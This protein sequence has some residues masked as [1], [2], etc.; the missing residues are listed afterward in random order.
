VRAG[1]Q[2]E[3][4][5]QR[6]RRL[7]GS[8]DPVNRQAVVVERTI[9]TPGRVLDGA[10]HQPCTGRQPDRLRDNARRVAKPPLEIR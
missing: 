1:G 8:S 3:W 7:G 10:T 2:H 5:W 4:K 9:L 6:A